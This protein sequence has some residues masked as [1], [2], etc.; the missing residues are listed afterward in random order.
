VGRVLYSLERPGPNGA[1]A[2]N[3]TK[4]SGKVLCAPRR[5]TASLGERK[6]EEVKYEEE[7]SDII[8]YNNNNF[9]I[10]PIFNHI[11]EI[12]PPK[13]KNLH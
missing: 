11:E 10:C 1:P 2:Q 8:F 9:S 7:K 13:K 12:I 4:E 6:H 5:P 3:D